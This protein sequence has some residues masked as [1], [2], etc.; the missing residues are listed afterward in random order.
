MALTFPDTYSDLQRVSQADFYNISPPLL[1][2][3][4]RY[5][6]AHPVYIAQYDDKHKLMFRQE[7]PLHGSNFMTNKSFVYHNTATNSMKTYG[8]DTM[9]IYVS[10]DIAAKLTQPPKTM[11]IN[12]RIR[13]TRKT[14]KSKNTRTKK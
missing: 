13:K 10:P 9:A 12:Q 2:R 1:E 3:L 6:Q 8:K 5:P 7:V 11:R 4:V 14:R